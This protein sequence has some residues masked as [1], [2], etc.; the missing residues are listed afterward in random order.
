LTN[1]SLIFET[2]ADIYN[3]SGIRNN[4]AV[5]LVAEERAIMQRFDYR[6]PRYC[7]D[8]PVQFTVQ[9]L[10]PIGRCTEISQEGMRLELEQPLL[11]YPCGK[12][13]M[14]YQNQAFE[15]NV[16]VAHVEASRVGV[17]FLYES[18]AEREAVAHLVAALAAPQDRPGLVLVKRT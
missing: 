16:R 15:F 4:D 18:D 9:D 2:S 14:T 7:V 6:C 1:H 13:A 3:L 5:L 8:L 10:T 11:S 12:V 17:V